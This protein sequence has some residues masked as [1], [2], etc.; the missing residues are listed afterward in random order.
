[1]I[2]TS[3]EEIPWGSVYYKREKDKSGEEVDVRSVQND[4]KV[5]QVSATNPCL[6]PP[7]CRSHR[8][9]FSRSF[10]APFLDVGGSQKEAS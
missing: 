4:G 1:M 8:H 5:I 7:P 2:G 9:T 10:G 6:P 3:D